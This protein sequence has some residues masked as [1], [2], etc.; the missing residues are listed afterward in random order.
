[1]DKSDIDNIIAQIDQNGDGMIDYE[2][3][4][5]MM[6]SGNEGLMQAAKHV[7]QGLMRKFQ[8]KYR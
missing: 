4:C 7:K 5:D 1:M 2:E 6:R 3:F 8:K